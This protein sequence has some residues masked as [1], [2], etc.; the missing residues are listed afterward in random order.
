MT[1]DCQYSQAAQPDRT[2]YIVAI[3][4]PNKITTSTDPTRLLLAKRLN[5]HA[6]DVICD[7]K[8]ESRD[9]SRCDCTTCWK[10]GTKHVIGFVKSA[11]VTP[12]GTANSAWQSDIR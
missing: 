6:S 10:T 12:P 1:L 7:Y 2:N 8:S 4:S 9:A 5:W 3:E 11:A